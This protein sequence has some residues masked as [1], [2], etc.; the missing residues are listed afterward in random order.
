MARGD[1]PY[2]RKSTYRKAQISP[3]RTDNKAVEDDEQ[4]QA[5]AKELVSESGG[6]LKGF[7]EVDV[8]GKTQ[9][10]KVTT[11][12]YLVEAI[13][14]VLYTASVRHAAFNDVQPDMSYV[15]ATPARR[16]P[17]HA[18]ISSA[19]DH[20]AVSRPVSAARNGGPAA[21]PSAGARRRLLHKTRPLQRILAAEP[22]SRR[23]TL[24]LQ[25]CP[26][27]S[28]CEDEGSQRGSRTEVHVPTP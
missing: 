26:S 19:G 12:A 3:E 5:W 15:P 4:L 18:A 1:K 16:L 10:G 13:T 24:K 25:G 28:E 6:R 7:G 14:M 21:Q 9:S 20:R 23:C 11:V 2:L 27:G 22:R 8:A 17:F